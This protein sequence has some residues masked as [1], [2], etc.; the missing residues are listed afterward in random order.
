VPQP[1]A[2]IAGSTRAEWPGVFL[3]SEL[4]SARWFA[5]M[6]RPGRADIWRVRVDSLWLEG[7]PGAS[8]SG[9]DD[10]MIAIEPIPAEDVALLE[11]DV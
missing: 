11:R 6:A 4:E 7:D 5:Q 1:R 3:C 2:G 10:W 8:G 9:D